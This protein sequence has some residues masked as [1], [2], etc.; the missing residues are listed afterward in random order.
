MSFN[1]LFNPTFLIFL[2]ILV[3]VVSLLIV[4]FEGKMREQNHK[5]ASMLSLVSTLAEDMNGVK[6]GLNHLSFASIGG[7]NPQHNLK[8]LDESNITLN[9]NN[10]SNLIDVSDDD[11]DD[12]S[13][14]EESEYSFADEINSDSNTEE[15]NDEDDLNEDSDNDDTV[16]DNDNSNNNDSDIKIFKLNISNQINDDIDEFCDINDIN[17]N[18]DNNDNENID[19]LEELEDSLSLSHS[20]TSEFNDDLKLSQL[21]ENINESLTVN[22]VT[23]EKSKSNNFTSDLKTINI[24]LEDSFSESLDFKKLPLQKLRNIVSEKGLTTEVSKLKKNELLKLLGVE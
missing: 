4:Y 22:N 11:S 16:D 19:D 14:T 3:L 1:D 2:G 23:E 21:D 12:E 9:L 7:E 6:F 10:N 24:N 8:H 20:E 5:I 18:N 13:N 15:L 17:D